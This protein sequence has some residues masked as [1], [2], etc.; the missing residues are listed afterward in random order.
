MIRKYSSVYDI[1]PFKYIFITVKLQIV[2]PV[3]IF[4]IFLVSLLV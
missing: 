1:F 3:Q 4:L 2:S